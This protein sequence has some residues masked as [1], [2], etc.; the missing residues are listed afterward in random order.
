M[1]V[2]HSGYRYGLIT[3]LG[4]QR[5]SLASLNVAKE[6][7]AVNRNDMEKDK[8]DKWA[9]DFLNCGFFVNVK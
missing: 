2:L 7:N 5:Y 8:L 9:N 6:Q 3:L 4:S 1:Q